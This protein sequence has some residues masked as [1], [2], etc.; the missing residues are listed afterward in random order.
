MPTYDQYCMECGW[1]EDVIR[2]WDEGPLRICPRCGK[3][4]Y[5]H[6]RPFQLRRGDLD[7]YY[8]ITLG[9]EFGS[10]HAR[11]EAAKRAGLKE[12][13]IT[14]KSLLKARKEVSYLRGRYSDAPD[15]ENEVQRVRSDAAD[16]IR[17]EK[18]KD[19]ANQNVDIAAKA[20]YEFLD[21]ELN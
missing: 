4:A 12:T 13:S 10:N 18:A 17:A 20:A 6:Y 9:H 2:T 1:A 5:Q 8:D 14:D 21:R 16:Q 19:L 11:S 3:R 15:V 7:S